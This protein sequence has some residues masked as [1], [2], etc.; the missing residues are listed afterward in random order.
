MP[1][2]LVIVES[3]AKAKT[4]KKF[5]GKDF[6][7]KASVGH[8]KDLPEKRLG[9]DIEDN[10]R[11]EY[12]VIRGKAKILKEL[13]E[14]A[15]KA[16]KVYLAPDP[17]REGEAIAWHIAESLQ[18]K[19]PEDIYRVLFNEITQQAVRQAMAHPQRIDQNKV[20][21]Q[22]TRRILDRLVGYKISPLLWKKVQ[23]GLSAGRVQSVALRLICEREREIQ[24]FVPQEYWSITARLEGQNP[25][26]FAAK[27]IKIGKKKAEIGDETTARQIVEGVRTLPLSVEKVTRKTQRRQP[28]PPFITSR[29]Q[30]EAANKLHFSAQKTMRIAQT[31]YEGVALGAEGEVGL[32]TYMRTDS[33]RVAPEAQQ[34]ARTYIQER[35]GRDYL[36]AKPR[37][38]RNRKGIQDAHEAIRPT[39]VLRDPETVRPYLTR[40]QYRL[41]A[42]IW[43]RFVASQMA[44]AVFDLTTVDIRGGE[45][46]FRATG[47]VLRFPGYL[48]L[49]QDGDQTPLPAEEES[50]EASAPEEETGVLPP[51]EEG[52]TLRLLDIIPKQHFTQPPP[53]YSEGSL[54]AEL[55]KRGIGRPSTYATILSTIRDRNYVQV[56]D[57]RFHPTELGMLVTELLVENF[58][59]ILNVE[60][61]ANMEEEL[62]KIEEG[63]K[64]WVTTL[65]EF[66]QSFSQNLVHAS[67][68]M[69]N[70][71]REVEET[72][73]RC[74]KCG[75]KMVIRWGR[76]GK[77]LACSGYPKCKNTKEIPQNG[78]EGSNREEEEK[79]EGVCERCGQPLVIK[80]G[81]YGKFIACSGYPRCTY[82]RSLTLGIPC[83]EEGCQGELVQRRSKRGR[84]FY[85]C[86]RYPDCTFVLWGKPIA[87]SCPV[88][89]Y[90]LLVEKGGKEP[91]ITCA[92][93][94]CAYEEVVGAGR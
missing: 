71:R 33:T 21:A 79:V 1:Q 4:L 39:S 47:S 18:G 32:I 27:L 87:Q 5:L 70:L 55:E 73:E 92:R 30:Q 46:L 59:S 15:L 40:D 20:L 48:R 83:P 64:D 54:V 67:V 36:P 66:Y 45:Y 86:S 24:N 53:R 44:A 52:E 82:S 11:P 8:V 35:F 60:F 16:D 72:E 93:S 51:L 69:R 50:E 42:L 6:T 29:L 74:E 89:H 43:E 94:S 38:Y 10:F 49:R 26:P 62:D 7:V 28:P 75:K 88:C 76:Y 56:I 9:V 57:R 85:G 23:Q 2:S 13:R 81:R 31:L 77:F 19:A 34:E 68:H 65:K 84:I 80:K 22:Q 37:T 12:V 61:T 25:P 78:E 17:D 90:P 41:Y 3:P 58:P 91:K 14:S 63:E